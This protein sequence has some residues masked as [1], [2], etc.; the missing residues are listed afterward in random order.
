M[1]DWESL[2]DVSEYL[3]ALRGSRRTQLAWVPSTSLLVKLKVELGLKYLYKRVSRWTQSEILTR[4][5]V[6][7]R[8]NNVV[9]Q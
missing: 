2:R 5:E 4:V 6:S 7:R 1:T 8:C 3:H 9:E